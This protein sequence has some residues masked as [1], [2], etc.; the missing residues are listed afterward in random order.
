MT[1]MASVFTRRLVSS[2]FFVVKV[3]DDDDD[4][5]DKL[6]RPAER[7]RS[8]DGAKTRESERETREN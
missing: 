3:Y 1:N 2:D 5:D 4:E 8:E 6:P 7:R